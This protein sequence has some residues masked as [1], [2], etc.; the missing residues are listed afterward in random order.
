MRVESNPLEDQFVPDVPNPAQV[1][2]PAISLINEPDLLIPFQEGTSIPTVTT[3]APPPTPTSSVSNCP[4][5]APC[6]PGKACP[7][8]VPCDQLSCSK[9][10]CGTV[11]N[12]QWCNE[13]CG[14]MSC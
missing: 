12:P 8:P 10:C 3:P 7:D 1:P 11:P 14:G 4:S 5:V 13:N 2:L 9:N 6:Q